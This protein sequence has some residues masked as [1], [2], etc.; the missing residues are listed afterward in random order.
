MDGMDD[1]YS[2]LQAALG[3]D[4]RMPSP[5]DAMPWIHD[6]AA[7]LTPAPEPG[8]GPQSEPDEPDP[9][10]EFDGEDGLEPEPGAEIPDGLEQDTE[11]PERDHEETTEGPPA[12]RVVP[13]EPRRG[14]E[15]TTKTPRGNHLRP[16]GG[17]GSS[18]GT[19]AA[20]LI[21]SPS[22]RPWDAP[23][24]PPPFEP[25]VDP[26]KD[27]GSDD[28]AAER[29]AVARDV[30]ERGEQA[31]E[32]AAVGRTDY[33][34]AV[35]DDARH[36][37]GPG[38][39]GTGGSAP[40]PLIG[41]FQ[42]VGLQSPDVKRMPDVIARALRDRLAR[43]AAEAGYTPDQVEQLVG[44]P[45]ARG[46]SIAALVTAFLVAEL[47]LDLELDEASRLA[48]RLFR[49]SDPL[50]A[51]VLTTLGSIEK[52]HAA[53]AARI[54]RLEHRV[55]DA[56]VAGRTLEQGVAWLL[57]DRNGENSLADDVRSITD[58]RLDD[59]IVDTSLDLLRRAAKHSETVEAR[60]EGRAY[61]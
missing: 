12:D 42:V 20:P 50:M 35:A 6:R 3:P 26:E 14:H 7:D 36:A 23:Q 2:D 15:E 47:D 39:G 5:D 9:E 46:L 58:A 60:R 13:E 10:P 41:R 28:V 59:E 25:V 8:P 17:S 52:R 31:R 43:C 54:E 51:A 55:A 18:G 34:E 1:L 22:S 38:T 30:A 45:N 11:E 27:T 49:S 40:L 61:R 48:V 56:A 16:G 33:K 24:S 37:G 32:L 19:E 53:T 21:S 57:A 44:G 29:E 4:V